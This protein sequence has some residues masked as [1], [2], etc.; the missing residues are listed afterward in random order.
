MLKIVSV[1][2]FIPAHQY[3]GKW[4]LFVAMLLFGLW[5]LKGHFQLKKILIAIFVPGKNTFISDIESSTAWERSRAWSAKIFHI[6]ILHFFTTVQALCGGGNL[7][8]VSRWGCVCEMTGS[9]YTFVLFINSFILKLNIWFLYPP[10]W[11]SHGRTL[12]LI[13]RSKVWGL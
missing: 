3:S 1:L 4:Y 12:H 8:I 6:A 2:H 10:S 11:P 5:H 9:S 13:R 7:G